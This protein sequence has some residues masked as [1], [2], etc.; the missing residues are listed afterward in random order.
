M[1]RRGAAGGA[2]GPGWAPRARRRIGR[3]AAQPIAA[4]WRPSIGRRSPSPRAWP[5]RL[6]L[7]I[8]SSTTARASS[9]SSSTSVAVIF[10]GVREDV[11]GVGA[12]A[13]LPVIQSVQHVAA[14]VGAAVS[15]LVDPRRV[16]LFEGE[17]SARST[18]DSPCSSECCFDGGTMRAGDRDGAAAAARLDAALAVGLEE[19]AEVS[20]RCSSERVCSKTET[21]TPTP[22]CLSVLS[23]SPMYARVQL[24]LWRATASSAALRAGARAARPDRR[25]HAR[26]ARSRRETMLSTTFGIFCD[27]QIYRRRSLGGGARR[28]AA[29]RLG[30]SPAW[31][32]SPQ[33]KRGNR[34]PC[35]WPNLRSSAF[36]W[37]TRAPRTSRC[38][39]KPS[40]LIAF[41]ANVS[42]AF[43]S[44]RAV[45]Q[46]E[47]TVVRQV[48]QLLEVG[49]HFLHDVAQ[50]VGGG[51]A[52]HHDHQLRRAA[53]LGGLLGRDKL[54]VQH[55]TVVV[56]SVQQQQLRQ[57]LPVL[58][59]GTDF[60]QKADLDLLASQAQQLLNLAHTPVLRPEAGSSP[61]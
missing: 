46:H 16:H 4:A 25:D 13:R 51:G 22:H 5:A 34:R 11:A 57:E 47:L 36:T 42:T 58:L 48:R 19:A 26:A 17:S 30:A 6:R 8:W 61:G 44:A 35:S 37:P 52:R 33:P 39:E 45:G 24:A 32:A 18:V 29:D 7:I 55:D 3:A 12:Q 50:E 40:T 21:V 15:V 1:R 59:G 49:V 14:E 41:L 23:S 2:A 10:A 27:V 43:R 9:R 56:V 31:P 53:P 20:V 54:K 38:A 60:S 28:E